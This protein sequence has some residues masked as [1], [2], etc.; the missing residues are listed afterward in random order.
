MINITT[1]KILSKDFRIIIADDD[2]DDQVMLSAAFKEIGFE[3]SIEN[4][5]NGEELMDYLFKQGKY[6]DNKSTAP[7]LI[8]LDLNMPKKDGRAVLQ[9]IRSNHKLKKIPVV[10]FTTSSNKDDIAHSYELGA[11]SFISKP[12]SY[13]DLKEIAKA[14]KNYWLDSVLICNSFL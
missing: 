5:S 8:L 4:I 9:E 14:I 2:D 6:Q 3:G 1:T 7:H 13:E 10:V 12:S 11:N